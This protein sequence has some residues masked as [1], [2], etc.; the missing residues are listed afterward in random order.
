MSRM[1]KG[2]VSVAAFATCLAL[3]SCTTAVQNRD[4]TPSPSLSPDI[5]APQPT[6]TVADDFE[7]V[8]VVAGIDTD[9]ANVSASGYVS[10]VVEDDGTCVF[11][12]SN[13]LEEVVA[14]STGITDARSTSCGTVQVPAESFVRGSWTVTLSYMSEIAEAVSKP[15]GLEIP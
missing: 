14:E 6:S 3:A 11:T 5:P 7:A 10:G 1:M 9:G 15:V 8:I 13:G 12:F 2:A 4:S